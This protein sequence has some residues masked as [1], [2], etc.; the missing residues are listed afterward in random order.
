MSYKC[1]LCMDRLPEGIPHDRFRQQIGHLKDFIKKVEYGIKGYAENSKKA[2]EEYESTLALCLELKQ[3]REQPQS[4]NT[5]PLEALK[6]LLLSADCAWEERREG[7][8]WHEACECARKAIAESEPAEA[9]TL[10]MVEVFK[11]WKKCCQGTVIDK[12]CR[13]GIR[14]CQRVES[15]L[16]AQ[17]QR[18]KGEQA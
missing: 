14:A 5:E 11:F 8:D 2:L 17:E 1:E 9:L 10:E 3:R 12:Q 7:H 18:L 16:T 4:I 13:C 15:W 6:G